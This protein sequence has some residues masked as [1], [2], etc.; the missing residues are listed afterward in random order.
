MNFHH[1][2]A[3][4]AESPKLHKEATWSSL[5]CLNHRAGHELFLQA[6][7]LAK[8]SSNHSESNRGLIVCNFKKDW[9]KE[10]FAYRYFNWVFKLVSATVPPTPL[11]SLLKEQSLSC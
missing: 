5:V 3:R 9:N 2:G 4:Q 1:T 10:W 7:F 8:K 11:V 6:A